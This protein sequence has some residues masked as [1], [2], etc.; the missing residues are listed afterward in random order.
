MLYRSSLRGGSAA[1][2]IDAVL[3]GDPHK[4]LIRTRFSEHGPDTVEQ[5]SGR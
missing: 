4:A 3:V 1:G 5:I 2:A